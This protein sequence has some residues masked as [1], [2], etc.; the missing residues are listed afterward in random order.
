MNCENY[1]LEPR[2]PSPPMKLGHSKLI[3]HFR[4][5]TNPP[6]PPIR[7]SSKG[8]GKAARRIA[9]TPQHASAP[10]AHNIE[11]KPR[12]EDVLREENRH[13]DFASMML[14]EPVLKGLK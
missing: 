5:P 1:Q 8:R 6:P 10:I 14:S 9:P 4:S 12:T 11:D 13:R 3:C 7:M 2:V